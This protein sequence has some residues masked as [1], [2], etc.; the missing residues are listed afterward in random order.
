[1]KRVPRLCVCVC[2]CLSL[3]L[4]RVAQL[5]GETTVPPAEQTNST[6]NINSIAGVY[7]QGMYMYVCVCVCVAPEFCLSSLL[8]LLYHILKP[9]S[10][11]IKDYFAHF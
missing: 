10:S 9:E 8:L 6:V 3:N 2:V 11:E 5:L 1:M 7:L 4:V